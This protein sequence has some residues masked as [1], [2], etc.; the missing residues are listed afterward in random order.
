MSLKDCNELTSSRRMRNVM[1]MYDFDTVT[2]ATLLCERICVMKFSPFLCTAS[3]VQNH[4]D[5]ITPW[6]CGTVVII[7]LTGVTELDVFLW[8]RSNFYF[9]VLL[10]SGLL[11]LLNIWY[12]FLY[13]MLYRLYML[14]PCIFSYLSNCVRWWGWSFSSSII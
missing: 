3:S 13:N 12:F 4:T 14:P 1:V 2:I 11:I 10:S 7:I 8:L 6:T 9:W 5:N